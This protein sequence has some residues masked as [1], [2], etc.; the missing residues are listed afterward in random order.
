MK[1]AVLEDAPF[2]IGRTPC[3]RASARLHELSKKNF[4]ESL[5]A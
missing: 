4:L 3:G 1:T 5:N 2:G